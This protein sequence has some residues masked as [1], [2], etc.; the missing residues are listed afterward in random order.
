MHKRLALYLSLALLGLAATFLWMVAQ[1]TPVARAQD[2]ALTVCLS[3][4]PDCQYSQVQEAVDAAM[5]GDTI[6]IA[7]GV[8]TGVQVRSGLT[9]TA[10]ISKSL[11][12]R[13]GYNVSFDVWDPLAYTTTLDAGKQGR[14]LL[15]SGSVTAT[16]EGL[17]LV[18]GDAGQDDGGGLY[19]VTSTVTITDCRLIGNTASSGG[20][21]SL[22]GG[23]GSVSGS[24]FLSNTAAIE[25]GAVRV[26]GSRVS[27]SDSR[28]TDNKANAG[29]GLYLQ[30]SSNRLYGNWILSNTAVFTGGGLAVVSSTTAISNNMVLDNLATTGGGLALQKSPGTLS[31]NLLAGN[32]AKNGGGLDLLSSDAKLINNI[33]V[34][35]EAAGSG[36]GLTIRASSPRLLHTT[37]A[38]NV[39]SGVAILSMGPGI[40]S[41]LRMTNTILVSHT[42]ALSVAAGSTT[43]IEATLWGTATWANE[44]DWAGAGTVI[45][46]VNEVWGPPAFRAPDKG[47]Y[48]IS[49]ESGAR[50]SGVDAG[51]PIDIDGQDRP[52]DAGFDMG[53]DEYYHIYRTLLPVVGH[54]YSSTL[55]I[56]ELIIL[57][58]DGMEKDW[59]W[60]IDTF[61]ALEIARAERG[62]A[63]RVCTLQEEHV[64][65]TIKVRAA[66]EENPVPG[67]TVIRYWPDAPLLPP[68]MVDWHDRGDQLVTNDAGLVEFVMGRGDKYF[69]PSPGASD[70][71]V[72]DPA[73]A[74]D[75]MKGLGMLDGTDHIHL[76]VEFCLVR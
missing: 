43:A 75:L 3:G 20:G 65:V 60:V 9:Q 26:E 10:L 29:G 18:N 13:G 44:T 36:G 45:T 24:A 22:V 74:S 49:G 12:L 5:A 62:A 30:S 1:I 6:L 23:W 35:N 40:S 4:P 76:N 73:Y 63:Y 57:D 34:D 32:K 11:T 54:N 66:E 27:L 68:E 61:G 58:K 28:F 59:D 53:A 69:P 71:W 52:H 48:H 33:V 64:Q 51:V 70:V 25:G 42:V 67:V 38:R 39:G 7:T 56:P 46:G 50:D 31:G 19:A 21:L 47:D 72:S 2:S 17:S 41:N 15:I 8:Y 14:V 16:L 37:I 55:A